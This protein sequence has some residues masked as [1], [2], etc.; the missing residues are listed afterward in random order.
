MSIPE[1]SLAR[2]V[3]SSPLYIGMA[4]DAINKVGVHIFEKYP[5]GHSTVLENHIGNFGTSAI[6]TSFIRNSAFNFLENRFDL[7]VS[8]NLKNVVAFTAVGLINLIAEGSMI[9]NRPNPELIEDVSMGLL[10]SLLFLL[11]FPEENTSFM[12]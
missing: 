2:K 11:S 3:F 12:N 5:L 10:A 9:L 4:L 1:S 8:S 7:F 6:L